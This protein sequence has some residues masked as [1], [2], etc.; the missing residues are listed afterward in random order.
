MTRWISFTSTRTIR[1]ANLGNYSP[2][3][4]YG[5]SSRPRLPERR[6]SGGKLQSERCSRFFLSLASN[7]PAFCIHGGMAELA[8]IE[9][10]ILDSDQN[11]SAHEHVI[12]R[13]VF[14]HKCP[15]EERGVYI[16]D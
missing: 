8:A 3:V 16:R 2:K 5:G 1:R 11:F 14:L 9:M 10:T 4:R 13:A 12:F 7:L 15:R 6:P